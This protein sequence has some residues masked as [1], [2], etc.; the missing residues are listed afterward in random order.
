MQSGLFVG[1]TQLDDGTPVL[2]LDVTAIGHSAGIPR[3]LQR[4]SGA[5]ATR[6]SAHVEREGLRVVLFRDLMGERRAIAMSAVEQVEHAPASAVRNPGPNAQIV[7][8]EE[9]LS[10]LGV[11]EG[12]ELPERLSVMRLG[13]GRHQLAYASRKVLEIATLSGVLKR[14]NGQPTVVGVTLVDGETAELIDCHAL[15]ASQDALVPAGRTLT[16]RLAGADGWMKSFLGPIVEAAGYRIAEGDEPADI[17]FVDGE[18][19]VADE[20][21]AIHLRHHPGSAG[22]ADTIYRYDRAGLMA[23]LLKAGEELAA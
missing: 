6:G 1:C 21:K 15:F 4:P 14:V 8:G 20:A 10:L 9:I 13:D 23:A 2:V 22:G 19:E 16:C 17:V 18:V 11:P 12:A 7:L 5:A 3:E